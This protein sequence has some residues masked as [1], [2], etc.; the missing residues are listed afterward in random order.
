MNPRRLVKSVAPLCHY[1]NHDQVIRT[2]Y[3]QRTVPG[4]FNRGENYMATSDVV[5]PEGALRQKLTSVV[6]QGGKEI[7]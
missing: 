5:S 1:E 2:S 3:P 6:G 4:Q 7:K